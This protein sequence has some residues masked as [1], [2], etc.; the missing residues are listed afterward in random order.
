MPCYTISTC[1]SQS[2]H[3]FTIHQKPSA[4]I[5]SVMIPVYLIFILSFLH[6][7]S[8]MPGLH[9]LSHLVLN[10]VLHF[11]PKSHLPVEP[12]LDAALR[13][14]GGGMGSVWPFESSLCMAIP[15]IMPIDDR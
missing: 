7:I 1:S 10:Q 11:H 8:R 6:V 2:L 13:G 15:P 5:C 14:R 3:V 4:I 12:V 9:S